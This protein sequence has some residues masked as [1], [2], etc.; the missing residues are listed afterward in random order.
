M[1]DENVTVKFGAQTGEVN[2]GINEV[3]TGLESLTPVV[4]D[5]A[6]TFAELFAIHVIQEFVS[7]LG[8]AYEEIAHLGQVATSAA[9][10][11]GLAVEQVQEF[12]KISQLVGVSGD[13]AAVGL[14]RFEKNLAT[15]GQA[16]SVTGQLL[17]EMGI[18]VK[19]A[20]G[21][22]RPLN[23]IMGDLSEKF[24][25]APDGVNKTA[26]AIEL[27]GR[28]GARLIPFLDQGRTGWEQMRQSVEATGVVMSGKLANAFQNSEDYIELQNMAFKGLA[29]TIAT[30]FRPSVDGLVN[31]LTKLVEE[32]NNNI[33]AG[34]DWKGALDVLRVTFEVIIGTIDVLI[35]AYQ[36]LIQVTEAAADAIKGNWAGATAH[37]ALY[38]AQIQHTTLL[39]KNLHDFGTTDP[40]LAKNDVLGPKPNNSLPRVPDISGQKEA[41]KAATEAYIATIKAE[42]EAD[43]DHFDQVMAL[44]NKLLVFL[45]L[46]Y[47]QNSAQ[48]QKELH[49]QEA[50]IR[51]H[52]QQIT[53]SWVQTFSF[54]SS[55]FNSAFTSMLSGAKS[56]TQSFSDLMIK[57]AEDAVAAI[58]EIIAEWLLFEIVTEGQGSWSDF[59]TL[60]GKGGGAGGFVGNLLGFDVGSSFVPSTGPA[61]IHQ[62]EIIVP[63]DLSAQIRAGKASL[64][65][66]S[67]GG[68]GDT[69]NLTI[70]AIDTQSGMQFLMNNKGAVASA[71]KGAARN[72]TKSSSPAWRGN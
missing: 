33:K 45:A 68:G 56:F 58:G 24:A 50:M 2:S 7:E 18:A 3:K 17:S 40:S 47:T 22:I 1:S 8:H 72:F 9:A 4:K 5:L 51:R 13:V 44:E 28:G 67:S 39:L 46:K 15:S 25:A 6:Q 61:L 55:D 57:M 63:P 37:L 71:A 26:V 23:D 41:D 42:Q 69:I 20:E 52:N 32:I 64:G 70:Q 62:G 12:G 14:Q 30:N 31:D 11:T 27:M 21:Q 54:I 16:S 66:Q 43:K 35:G 38:D 49:N 29:I 65:S 19:N 48:Y 59:M 53:N 10:Q 36:G 34:G 60:R